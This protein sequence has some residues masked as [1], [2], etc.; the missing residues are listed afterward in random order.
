MGQKLRFVLVEM[1][2]VQSILASTSLTLDPLSLSALQLS[3]SDRMH[4]PGT[5]TA[6]WCI[7]LSFL[8]KAHAKTDYLQ[9]ER[10]T[11]AL[12]VWKG[13]V[14]KYWSCARI[15]MHMAL[16]ALHGNRCR[17]FLFLISESG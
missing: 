6:D 12:D 7:L 4:F 10:G 9:E 5:E 14:R 17:A 8:V 16:S 1:N 2:G 3:F 15:E 11:V 13:N